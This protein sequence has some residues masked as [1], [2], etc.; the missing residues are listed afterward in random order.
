M[1]E[2]QQ[3]E[4][5][6][7]IEQLEQEALDRRVRVVDPPAVHAVADVEQQPEADRH[8]V[9]RELGDRLPD[10]VLEDLEG[11]LR[12]ILHE[13]A[14]LV[15]DRGDHA[16]DLDP[17]LEQL[18]VSDGRL[19]A[20]RQRGER[21]AEERRDERCEEGA[22]TVMLAHSRKGSGAFMAPAGRPRCAA[23]D[24]GGHFTDNCAGMNIVRCCR[25]SCCPA[26]AF[27]GLSRGASIVVV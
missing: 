21:A 14:V 25:C 27:S 6:G 16:G 24:N 18:R 8:P 15:G 19:L 22:H 12:Q 17:R 5:V 9:A 23:V 26:G 3:E 4:L 11:V 1:I 13:P 20:G 7:R 10:A 2:R